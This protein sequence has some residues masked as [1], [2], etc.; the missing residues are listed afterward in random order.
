MC[1]IE[2]FFEDGTHLCGQPNKNNTLLIQEVEKHLFPD[3]WMGE[4]D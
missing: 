2:G 4:V 3:A 1:H